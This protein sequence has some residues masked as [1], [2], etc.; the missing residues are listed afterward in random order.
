MQK[1]KRVWTREER[2]AASERS[3]KALQER[4]AKGEAVDLALRAGEIDQTWRGVRAC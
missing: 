2:A 3:R 1:N 4:R